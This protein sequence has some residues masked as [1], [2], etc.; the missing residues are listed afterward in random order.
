MYQKDRQTSSDLQPPK[1]FSRNVE[2]LSLKDEGFYLKPSAEKKPENTKEIQ[3]EWGGSLIDLEEEN[4]HDVVDLAFKLFSS[5]NDWDEIYS[6]GKSR[7]VN[8]RKSR[9]GSIVESEVIKINENDS[10]LNC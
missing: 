10:Y 7:G 4:H 1:P 9:D 8:S 5:A 2:S 6:K 3:H